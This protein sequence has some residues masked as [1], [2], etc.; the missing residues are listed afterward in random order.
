MIF[1]EISIF[2][3]IITYMGEVKEKVMLLL[4]LAAMHRPEQ[5]KQMRLQGEVIEAMLRPDV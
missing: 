3:E 1:L 2:H 4:D 5:N